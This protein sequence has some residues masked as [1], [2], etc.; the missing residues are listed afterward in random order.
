LQILAA[1]NTDK[2]KPLVTVEK[3]VRDHWAE[4][5]RNYYQ[6]YDY[7]GVETA[8]AEKVFARIVE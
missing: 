1:K 2:T 3:I 6:R 8:D 4:Y 7:E 5:G